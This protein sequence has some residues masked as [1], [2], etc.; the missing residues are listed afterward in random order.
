VAAAAKRNGIGVLVHTSGGIA[1]CQ[2][3]Q[4]GQQSG[5]MVGG[6][7]VA[8]KELERRCAIEYRDLNGPVGRSSAAGR[9]DIRYELGRGRLP[10]VKIE[11]ELFAFVRRD[12]CRFERRKSR[13]T[14]WVRRRWGC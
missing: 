2:L 8:P 11:Q 3:I 1:E 12:C 10:D 6:I 4:A 14:E 13:R 7:V 5:W 9:L